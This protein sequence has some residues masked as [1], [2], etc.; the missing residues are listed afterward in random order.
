MRDPRARAVAVAP[1]PATPTGPGPRPSADFATLYDGWFPHVARWLRALSV[2]EADIEDVAQDVFLVVRRRLPDFDGHNVPGWIYRITSRQAR[3]HRRRR[4]VQ[5]FFSRQ[6][7]FDVDELPWN[8]SSAISLL[9]TREK[10]RLLE[11]LVGKLS[12][13]RRV[14][15]WLFEVEGYGG[16]EI[17]EILDV[18]LNTVWTRLHHARKDFFL[19]LAEHRRGQKEVG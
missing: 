6:H 16:E 12:E 15:F 9:E 8:G 4:W 3:Q 5:T 2:P 7:S 18:P 14:A 17:A 19:L 11:R 13:K 10:Q 1:Q